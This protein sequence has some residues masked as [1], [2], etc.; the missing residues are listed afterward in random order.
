MLHKQTSLGQLSFI[1]FIY[2]YANLIDCLMKNFDD[3]LKQSDEG[4]D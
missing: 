2:S 1:N 4:E 3:Q